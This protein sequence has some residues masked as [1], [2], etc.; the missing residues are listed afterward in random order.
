MQNCSDMIQ[1][2]TENSVMISQPGGSIR[3]Q[4]NSDSIEFFDL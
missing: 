3:P 1:H 2:L 4:I